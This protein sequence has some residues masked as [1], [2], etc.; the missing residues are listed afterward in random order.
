MKAEI[1]VQV[2]NWWARIFSYLSYQLSL[3]LTLN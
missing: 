3:L 1:C 2:W